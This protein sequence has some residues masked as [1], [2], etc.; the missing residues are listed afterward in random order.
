MARRIRA[1]RDVARPADH[2]AD[3]DRGGRRPPTARRPS[4]SPG[5]RRRGATSSA[6][7][8][9]SARR[10]CSRR[11]SGWRRSRRAS[12]PRSPTPGMPRDVEGPQHLPGSPGVHGVLRAASA[13][14]RRVVGGCCGTTPEHINAMVAR[15]RRDCAASGL[16]TRDA[17]NR[18]PS[19]ER[20]RRV[21]ASRA[22]GLA[23]RPVRRALAT[24]RAKLAGGEFVTSVELVPP[25]GFDADADGRGRARPQGRRR[26]RR[27]HPRR[28]ARAAPHGRA[29]A[30]RAH[31]AA[32]RHRDGRCTTP[33]ATATCSAS[34][35]PARR[36][37]M[38]LRNLLLITGDPPKMGLSGRDGRVRHRLDRADQPRVAAESRARPR[39]QA[40]R[41]ADA[42]RI[43]VGVNPGGAR[44]R[45]GAAALRVQG[46]GGRRVRRHAAG[47][48]RGAV[49]AVPRAR[50]QHVRM[51]VVAGIL[52]FDCARNAEFMANEVPGVV[53]ARRDPRADAHARTTVARSR[54]RRG[55][56]DRARDARARARRRAGRAGLGAVRPR[57]ARDLRGSRRRL[58]TVSFLL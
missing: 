27:Q 35:R 37:A 47:V 53:G 42:L 9:P 8:A 28:A 55:R 43:G 6:S 2:R 30:S 3:D 18:T 39:R 31:R 10:R 52:P 24:G 41:R 5:A 15:H 48:R 29:A 36:H 14:Q 13:A 20:D 22:R 49:R 57:G 16:G 45:R 50:S 11:S 1:V 46:R 32:G 7:T 33:A 26:R 56:R 4:A 44:P 54:R 12:C 19:V 51:P 17:R 58:M 34:S 23:G 21:A 25:R 38:G 40:D